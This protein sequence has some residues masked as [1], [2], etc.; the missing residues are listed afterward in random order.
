[1]YIPNP[2]EHL[3]C[4]VRIKDGEKVIAQGS[5]TDGYIH[6][7]EVHPDY[8]RQGYAT[9]LISILRREFDPEWL[10]VAADNMEAVALYNNY[11]FKIAEISDGYYKMKKD[12]QNDM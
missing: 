2:Y 8:R 12:K 4:E 1:M 7:L 3:T 9:R 6:D 10:W 11:G 5:A